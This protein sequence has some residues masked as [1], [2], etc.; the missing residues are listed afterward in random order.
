MD[1]MTLAFI[2]LSVVLK[3]MELWAV[4]FLLNF[5]KKSFLSIVV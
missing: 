2:I 5:F 1:D 4:C 3:L